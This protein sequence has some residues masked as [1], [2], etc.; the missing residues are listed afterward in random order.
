MP[1]ANECRQNAR[2]CLE[3]A[4]TAVDFYV[5]A[6]LIELAGDFQKMAATRDQTSARSTLT[7][8]V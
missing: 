6:A 2:D 8:V 1:T 7:P 3:L 5:H 4:S